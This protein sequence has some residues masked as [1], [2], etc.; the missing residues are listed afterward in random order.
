MKQ[1]KLASFIEAS[2]NTLIGF[3]VSFAI[4][5]IAAMWTGVEYSNSQHWALVGIFTVSSVLRGYIVR[6]FFNS[7]IHNSAK[8]FAKKLINIRSGK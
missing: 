2:T 6:R 5:P 4:W 7:G 1:T 8:L 3:A